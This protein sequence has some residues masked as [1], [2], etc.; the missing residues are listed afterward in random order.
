MIN[1]INIDQFQRAVYLQYTVNLIILHQFNN[2]VK[3]FFQDGRNVLQEQ[4]RPDT[5]VL[6]VAI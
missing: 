3:K 1:M 6:I 2:A 4:I 5:R